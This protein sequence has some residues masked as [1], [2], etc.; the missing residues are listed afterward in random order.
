MQRAIDETN[1]RREKQEAFNREHGITPQ[2]LH[3]PVTDV[4]D[5]GSDS[6]GQERLLAAEPGAEYKLDAKSLMAEIAKLEK[7]MF[8]HAQNLEFEQA[9]SVRDQVEALR[10]KVVETS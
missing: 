7:Q 5:M 6:D 10:A 1:R 8:E 4:M 2:P 3:K 9:A